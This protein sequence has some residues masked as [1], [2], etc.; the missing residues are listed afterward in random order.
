MR[1]YLG[2]DGGGTQTTAWL[3]DDRRQVIARAQ[4][5]PSNPTKVGMASAQAQIQRAVDGCLRQ[6]RPAPRCI[7]V[8]CAGIAGVDNPG[9]HDPL[10]QWLRDHVPAR[11]YYVTTDAAIALEAAFGETPGILVI[12]GTGSIAYGRNSKGLTLRCGGWGSL[13]DDA[14]SGYEL[15]RQAITA[16]LRDFDRRGPRTLLGSLICA[17]MRLKVITDVVERAP[18]P[19]EIAALIPVVLRAAR[20]GDRVARN[21]CHEAGRELAELA[22]ALHGR[23]AADGA[24]L[25][26]MCAG[27]VFHSSL[28]VRRSFA[29]HLRGVIPQS[30]IMLLRRQPVEGALAM[31]RRLDSGA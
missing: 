11:H 26:V 12:A 9:R 16:A 4:A 7:A 8:I 28:L 30:R 18:L 15:G 22:S 27:G 2:I 23:L 14:G 19:H 17:A 24:K 3:A 13:F 6:A 21:L 31:A 10:I 29:A 1:H 5:G 20:R 25:H